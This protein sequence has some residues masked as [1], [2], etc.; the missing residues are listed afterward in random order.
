MFFNGWEG[1]ARV[2]ISGVLTYAALIIILRVSGKR[3]L[4]KMNMFDY[5]ITV[6]LGS[7]F[8]T[9]VISKDVALVEGVAAIGL[10]AI[11][12]YLIAWWTIRSKAAERVIKGEPALLVY[13]GEM[14]AAPMKR[15]RISED[16]IYAVLR[17]NDIHDLADAGAV[18]L[19]TD[20]SLTVLS[21]TAQP[22]ATLATISEPDRQKYTRLTE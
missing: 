15:E 17:S 2:L 20:G 8:A 6:A 1:V 5:V 18:V 7:L 9:I 21:R 10:L 14:L 16:D 19:E 13:Q 11:L 4:S 3:T 22:P 12:Q